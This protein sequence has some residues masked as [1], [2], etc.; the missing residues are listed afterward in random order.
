MFSIST[1]NA[2]KILFSQGNPVLRVKSISSYGTV[3]G[4]WQD[5]DDAAIIFLNKKESIL[6]NKG[7]GK[8]TLDQFFPCKKVK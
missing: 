7:N 2:L 8:Y 1:K 5:D 4:N 6:E 3:R